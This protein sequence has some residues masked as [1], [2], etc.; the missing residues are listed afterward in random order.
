VAQPARRKMLGDIAVGNLSEGVH[1]GIG[2]ARAVDANRLAADRL[3][4]CLQRAL[5]RG[6]IVLD[7]PAAIRRAVIFD[8][9]FVA[10]H[11]TPTSRRPAWAYPAGILAP[12]SV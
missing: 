11:V 3:D 4:R 12:S 10:G 5:H 1:A 9:Q 7:L 8:G 2:A 6:A